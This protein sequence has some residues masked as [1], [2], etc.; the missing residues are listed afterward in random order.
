MDRVSKAAAMYLETWNEQYA[1]VRDV[2]IVQ[3]AV[4]TAMQDI[5]R[6]CDCTDPN[7]SSQG[8]KFEGW[9]ATEYR[10]LYKHLAPSASFFNYRPRS[11]LL[12]GVK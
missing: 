2:D 7:G 8:A 9:S 11:D 10:E 4:R 3:Y 6:S 5:E 1:T 12:P